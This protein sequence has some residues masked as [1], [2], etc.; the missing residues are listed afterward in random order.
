MAKI[1]DLVIIEKSDIDKVHQDLKLLG[2]K[3]LADTLDGNIYLEYAIKKVLNEV[4][5][6]L[7]Q[8]SGQF[9]SDYNSQKMYIKNFNFENIEL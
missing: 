4:S 2:H 6:G 9:N 1:K 8:T 3:V 5:K 7:K